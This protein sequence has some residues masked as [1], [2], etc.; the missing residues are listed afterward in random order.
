M[1]A[2]R[3]ISNLSPPQ[4]TPRE[5]TGADGY[6]AVCR[7]SCYPGECEHLG[8]AEV[9]VQKERPVYPPLSPCPLQH[10][11]GCSRFVNLRVGPA[12]QHLKGPG[13]FRI[14]ASHSPPG[15]ESELTL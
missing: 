14:A 8:G 2:S 13:A 3:V 7:E 5:G 9:S 6:P 11:S 4:M 15:P 10:C 1:W 12:P